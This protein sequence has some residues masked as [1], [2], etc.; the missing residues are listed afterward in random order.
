M[1]F[2]GQERHDAGVQTS[3]PTVHSLLS[4]SVLGFAKRLGS[5]VALQCPPPEFALDLDDKRKSL[6]TE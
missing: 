4:S 5:G 1:G 3:L 2:A 6:S